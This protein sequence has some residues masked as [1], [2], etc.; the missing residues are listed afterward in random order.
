M[1]SVSEM[2]RQC[3]LS[4]SRFY[5]LVVGGTFPF[6]LYDVQT[7]RP[8]YPA[9]LQHVCL[10]VRQRNCGINGRPVMFYAQRVL[11]KPRVAPAKMK[12]KHADL[13]D[14]IKSLGLAATAAQVEAAVT[15]LF[16][17]GTDSVNHGE[18]IRSVFVHLKKALAKA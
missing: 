1:V 14:A 18:V 2:A 6:P 17:N 4:R 13:I 15:E 9:E 12:A 10:E 5:Q 7:R 8:F 11:G 3:A 16:P